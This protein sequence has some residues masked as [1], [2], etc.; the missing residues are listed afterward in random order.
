MLH[1]VVELD[2]LRDPLHCRRESAD[3]AHERGAFGVAQVVQLDG[4]APEHEAGVAADR[5]VLVDRHP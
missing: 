2:R 1:L 3:V 4:M 5:R